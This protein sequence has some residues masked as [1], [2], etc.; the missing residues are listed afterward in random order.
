MD[1]KKKPQLKPLL[2]ACTQFTSD[3][4]S[5]IDKMNAA[6]EKVFDIYYKQL[7]ESKKY[8]KKEE[9]GN[10]YLFFDKNDDTSYITLGNCVYIRKAT[11]DRQVFL[12][13][14]E[15]VNTILKDV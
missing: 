8:Y 4:F 12:T 15:I 6:S 7:E 1:K 3:D 9:E 14:G 5:N 2:D 11:Y 13:I 10:T